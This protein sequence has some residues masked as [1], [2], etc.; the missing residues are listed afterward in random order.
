M[1][2]ETETFTQTFTLSARGIEKHFQVSVPDHGGPVTDLCDAAY[3]KAAEIA[4]R[5]VGHA[6]FDLY[7]ED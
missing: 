2:T 1:P 7:S 6:D 5:I 4:Q 3:E